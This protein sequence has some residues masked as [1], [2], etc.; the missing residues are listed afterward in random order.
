M[1]N[2]SEVK[3]RAAALCSHVCSKLSSKRLLSSWMCRC[4]CEWFMCIAQ[5]L[6]WGCDFAP[7]FTSAN[8]FLCLLHMSWWQSHGLWG[9]WLGFC[10]WFSALQLT[11]CVFLFPQLKEMCRRELD[12]SESEIKKNGSIIGEYKQVCTTCALSL[13]LEYLNHITEAF[14][15]SYILEKWN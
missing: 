2:P 10:P 12:K 6:F 8:T 3:D 1:K 9:P 14:L 13:D 7:S 5:R 11:D 15:F 4:N